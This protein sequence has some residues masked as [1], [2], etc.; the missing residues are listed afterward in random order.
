MSCQYCSFSHTAGYAALIDVMRI[1]TREKGVDGNAGK[2]KLEIRLNDGN[3][4]I[5]SRETA[6]LYIFSLSSLNFQGF[7][8]IKVISNLD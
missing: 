7:S 5:I 1:E 2:P 8:V 3:I 6:L 4:V